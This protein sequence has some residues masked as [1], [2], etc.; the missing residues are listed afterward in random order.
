MRT[1]AVRRMMVLRQ[2]GLVYAG[3]QVHHIIASVLLCC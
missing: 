3:G 2:K 1:V